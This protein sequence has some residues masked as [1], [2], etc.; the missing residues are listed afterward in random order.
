MKFVIIEKATGGFKI[1]RPN[2]MGEDERATA[3]KRRD[4][5]HEE[6]TETPHQERFRE[7]A[8]QRR[9]DYS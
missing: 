4:E 8:K 9:E 3:K 1:A 6:G 2:Q 5:A 7:R